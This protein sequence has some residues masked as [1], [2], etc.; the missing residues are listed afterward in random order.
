[1]ADGL[2][3]NPILNSPFL[4]PTRH[5]KF[6]DEAITNE[7]VAGRRSSS[8]F[9]PIA[10][11]KKKGKQLAFDTEWTQDRIEENKTVNRIRQRIGM[12]REGGHVGTV[13]MAMLIAWQALNKLANAQDARF[14]DT[15]LIVSPGITIRD[16]LRV[17]YPNDPKDH[18]YPQRL[19]LIEFAHDAADRLYG[20]MSVDHTVRPMV[21]RPSGRSSGRT[22]LS[23]QPVTSISTRRG[24]SWRRVPIGAMFRTSSR[25]PTVGS[26]KWRK[27]SKT[28]TK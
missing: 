14:S 6:T 20:A 1:M 12:W 15:F 21:H 10:R 19:L 7:V 13:V 16:R 11:P 24:R 18:T 5:F 2:I 26:R 4:E 8:Y 3:E 25:I 17:L 27:P 22:T 23:A 28:W 9:I